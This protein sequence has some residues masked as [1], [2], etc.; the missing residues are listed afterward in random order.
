MP[1]FKTI[2]VL[3]CYSK[4]EFNKLLGTKIGFVYLEKGWGILG[5][6]CV[7]KDR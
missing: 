5:L 7:H 2:Y 3:F 4:T 6:L 1:N